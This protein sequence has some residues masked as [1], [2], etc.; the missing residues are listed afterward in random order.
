MPDALFAPA[1]TVWGSPTTWLETLGFVLAVWMVVGNIFEKLW[2]WPLA[3]ISSLLYLGLF[4]RSKLYGDASLQLF[5][6][7]LAAWGWWQWWRG[8]TPQGASLHVTSLRPQQAWHVAIACL[9]LWPLTAFFLLTYTDSDVPWWDAFPTAVSLVAQYLLARKYLENWLLWT[10]VNV[11]SIG[12]Y[13]YKGLWLTVVL[14]SV[15]IALS[16]VGW[17]TWREHMRSNAPA[18][19][20]AKD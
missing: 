16:V 4:W 11:V 13:A 5:F 9:V 1:F 8:I 2:A 7:V 15:F 6:A 14:Y 12:L 18:P 17:R 3:I 19:M 10:V 20:L